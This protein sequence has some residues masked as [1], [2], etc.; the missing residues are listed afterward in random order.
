MTEPDGILSGML[1]WPHHVD[2]IARVAAHF[3]AQPDV[4]ALLLTGSL[5]HGF[6]TAASD[7]D[8]VIVVSDAE[9]QRRREETALTYYDEDLATYEGGYV[10]G[11]FVS[12]GFLRQVAERGN[13]ATRWGYEGARIL[14]ARTPELAPLLDEVV[15]FP[16]AEKAQRRTRFTAQLLAW[17]WY[18]E[19]ARAK[20]DVYLASLSLDRVVLFACRLVLNE[21]ELLFPFHKWLRRVAQDAAH[22]PASFPADVDALYADSSGVDAFVYGL[23]D[24]YGIDRGDAERTWGAWFMQDTELSWMSGPAPVEDL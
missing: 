8:I 11:K 7:V 5:A 2:T 15:A 10:D 20:S 19:Q 6:A 1:L 14:F 18:A 17:R 16:A 24:F 12:L 3:A 23:L 9:W 4:E 22:R 13:D 21:N